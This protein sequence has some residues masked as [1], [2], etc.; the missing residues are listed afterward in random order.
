MSAA[1]PVT[2]CRASYWATLQLFASSLWT[3][4]RHHRRVSGHL[5]VRLAESDLAETER[6]ELACVRIACEIDC[7]EAANFV[8]AKA[9]AVGD[10]HHDCVAVG[11]PEL[12]V[13]SPGA[14]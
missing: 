8:A 10:L 11:G 6:A 12:P 9:V 3:F 2:G 4:V 5:R 1:R 13:V 14:K 7:L